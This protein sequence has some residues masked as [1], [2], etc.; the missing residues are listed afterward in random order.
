MWGRK[1]REIERLRTNLVSLRDTH[2]E[3]CGQHA[4]LRELST[5]HDAKLWELEENEKKRRAKLRLENNQL[6]E[7]IRRVCEHLKLSPAQFDHEVLDAL[8]Q[9]ENNTYTRAIR[10]AVRVCKSLQPH[11]EDKSDNYREGVAYAER[12]IDAALGSP[13]SLMRSVAS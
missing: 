2:A 8:R 6:H 5:Q 7:L 12:T 9:L 3:L 1:Q 4:A 11:I 10:D 13:G